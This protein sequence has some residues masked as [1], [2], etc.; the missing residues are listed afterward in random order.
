MSHHSAEHLS[1]SCI[2][3]SEWP[4]RV[5]GLRVEVVNFD[6]WVLEDWCRQDLSFV[7][8]SSVQVALHWMLED[9][10]VAASAGYL[11]ETGNPLS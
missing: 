9:F 1:L 7:L 10:G 11:W 3:H 6:W 2:K 8:A 5:L 4:W